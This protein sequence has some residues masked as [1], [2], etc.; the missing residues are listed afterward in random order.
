MLFA[1]IEDILTDFA[2]GKMVVLMDDENR[3]NEGD[4]FVA[5]E[6]CTPEIINFMAQH[7]RGLICMTIT[8]EIREKIQLDYLP[9]RNTIHTTNFAVSF[10]AVS[11]VTTGISA[12]DRARSVLVASN[13]KVTP[14]DIATP[15]HIF[16]VVAKEGGVLI[17]AGHTE[18][19][20]D[21]ARLSNLHS[22]A[23]VIVE[24]MNSDGTMARRPDLA[25][26]CTLHDIKISTIASLINYRNSKGI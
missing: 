3:E 6:K 11:G 12:H 15:G 4:L 10:E 20:C 16:P 21:L 19:G 18:A 24:I 23:A 17:R 7:A 25:K 9:K 26:F 8:E 5:A 1:P 2:A 14:N 13:P 22:H